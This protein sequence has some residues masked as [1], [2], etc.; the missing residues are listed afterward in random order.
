[1]N[2][3]AL[4]F[5]LGLRM[6]RRYPGI[7]AIGTV[8]MAVA[9]ALGMLYFEGL[10]KALHPTLPVS[11]GDRIVTVRYWDVG[12]R[13]VEE[14]SLHDFTLA[15][16]TVKAIED[17]GA[18]LVFTRNLVT[19]DH[20]VE[21]V[22][23]AE[24][25]ASAF[26][27][28]G[29]PPLLGRTL[30]ARDEGPAEP[31]AVVIGERIWTT[32]FDR[33]PSVVGRSVTVGG[34]DGTIVGVMP[35]RFGFPVNE[36]LWLPLRAD[37]SRLAPRTGPPV[38]IFGRLAAGVSLR[39]AQAEL[40][41]I[42][43]RLAATAPEAYKNL[44]PRVVAYGTPPL[45]GDT[46]V[47]KNA[48]YAA[49]GFFLLLLAVICTNVA[50]LVFARTATRGWE[51]TVR[52][53]LGAS[54]GRIIAQLFAE[55]LVLAAVAALLGIGVAKLALRWGVRGIG[56]DLL[57]FWITDSLS[58]ITLLYAGLL[59]LL[60]AVIVG[61][62]PALRVTGLDVQ[63]AL[64]RDQAA[65]ASLKFGGLWTTVIVAQVAITVA[66]IPLAPVLVMA[67]NRW[68]QRAEAVGGDRYLSATVAFDRQEPQADSAALARE[69]QSLAELE[70][71]LRAEP[72][73]EQ[74][75][76]A[77]RLPVMD[78][79]KCSLEVD[80]T[81]GAPA[82]GLRVST[83][84][85][86]SSGFFAAFGSAVVAGR[87]FS[88][89][90]VERGD[91]VIV[92][93]SFTHLVFGDHNPLGQR[94]RITHSE[95]DGAV[96]DDGW[97]EVVGM[98]TDVGWQMPEPSEQAAIYHPA[99]LQPGTN[100]SVAVRVHDPAG[101]APRLRLLANAVDAEMNL[102]DVRL[103]SD[104]GGRGATLTWTM[105]YV[106]G[107]VSLLVL[108]LSASGIHAL[109]SFIVTRRTR[110]IGIRM[111]LGSPPARI[112]SGIFMRA[113]LQVAVGILAG[114]AVVALKIDF[115]SV[116]QV[117]MLVGADAVMLIAGLVACT[118]PLRRALAI[119]PTDALRAEA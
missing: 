76:F 49:N 15:R 50:T 72:G 97:Y 6:L 104:V 62:L 48:L 114:S 52:S 60:A 13:T 113:F 25:T 93:Q 28:M 68:G 101:F 79:S 9:I 69:R 89:L 119:N 45:E 18:A 75:A 94:I 98:V 56:A 5:K 36:G 71:R 109:L 63:N 39:Q 81:T 2:L 85:H 92:N 20:G 65:G 103:L 1:M 82:T 95:E 118:L 61:V 96:A 38:S 3:S 46:P 78:T 108:L 105:T 26:R 34:A 7:T 17:F 107:V 24:V 110:E 70:R 21:A 57:P 41:G 51:V 43:A 44:Q 14:R 83:L 117:L 116:T 4:D 73:V 80:T 59:T 87:N 19:E 12:R 67:S 77:D 84:A 23:G 99:L 22:R 32:R 54:R 11:G 40:D 111:A 100:L 10:N 33:D 29:T 31:L 115:G 27:L 8:A 88:P 35:E 53:A 74:V 91:V 102:T 47:I 58:P 16:T 64:R 112:V 106:A 30:T 86:V 37:G 42:T 66:L 55:A 90:D